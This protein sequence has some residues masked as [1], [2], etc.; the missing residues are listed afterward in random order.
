MFFFSSGFNGYRAFL[1]V[2]LAI[3]A[4]STPRETPR[5]SLVALQKAA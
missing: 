3:A 1:S 4:S 5:V 2:G